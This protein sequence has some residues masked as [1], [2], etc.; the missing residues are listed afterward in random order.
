MAPIKRWNPNFTMLMPLDDREYAEPAIDRE[1]PQPR[2]GLPFVPYTYRGSDFS[3]PPA[4][5]LKFSRRPRRKR[6]SPPV[7]PGWLDV[8]FSAPREWIRELPPK[9]GG[10]L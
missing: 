5:E 8:P 4:L 1:H 3:E 6:G 10:T 7:D 9:D 2:H